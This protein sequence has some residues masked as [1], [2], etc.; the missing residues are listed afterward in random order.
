MNDEANEIEA[1]L[2]KLGV[3]P[4]APTHVIRVGNCATISELTCYLPTYPI[5]DDA[6]A[7]M[8]EKLREKGLSY[9]TGYDSDRGTCWAEVEF[10]PETTDN[11]ELLALAR[12][13][14]A[15]EAE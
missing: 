9:T 3:R 2:K 7:A 13:V 14:N 10:E 12:A 15:M 5:G 1:A 4:T 11:T 6:L 8:K